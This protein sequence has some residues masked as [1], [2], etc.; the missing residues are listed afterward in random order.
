M[1]NQEQFLAE[2]ADQ[3]GVDDLLDIMDQETIDDLFEAV[4]PFDEPLD[5]DLIEWLQGG[6]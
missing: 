2:V 1:K 6:A 3:M 4:R 5:D